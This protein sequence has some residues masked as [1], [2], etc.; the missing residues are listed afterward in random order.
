MTIT[1]SASYDYCKVCSNSPL[2]SEVPR[3]AGWQV[4]LKDTCVR[5]GTA[6]LSRLLVLSPSTPSSLL[7]ELGLHSPTEAKLMAPAPAHRTPLSSLSF[8]SAV[9]SPSLVIPT[10]HLTLCTA[11]RILFSTPSLSGQLSR[12]SP[13]A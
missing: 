7:T 1:R 10:H 2:S 13:V 6:E 3:S 12:N 9:S 4:L 5:T 8:L 11:T